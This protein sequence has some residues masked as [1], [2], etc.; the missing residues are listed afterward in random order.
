[1]TKIYNKIKDNKILFIV[2]VLFLTFLS[3]FN[4]L[5]KGIIFNHDINFHLHRI[6]AL[7]DSIRIHKYIPVYF[8]YLNGFGYGNGLFYPDIF[9]YIPACLNYIGLSI[10]HSY[11]IFVVLINLLSILTMYL[12]VIRITKKKY[13]AYTSMILYSCSIYRLI[14][15]VERGSLGEMMSFIF[16][17]LVILGLYEILYG[18]DKK[19]ILLSLGLIGLC[20]SHVIT[21][22]LICIS[23]GIIVLINIK[24]LKDKKRLFNLL[25][26]IVIS[27][28]VTSF[29]WMPMLE[30]VFSNKFNFLA[31][32]ADFYNNVVP[33][34]ALFIDFPLTNMFK[35]WVP[36]GI[37]L[38]YYY[39]IYKHFKLRIKDKFLFSIYTVGTLSIVMAVFKLVWK[40]D[41][42]KRI[43]NIIQFPWRFYIIATSFLTIGLSIVIKKFNKNV[44][45]II[46]I[47][48]VV[49]FMGN[50]LLYTFNA[51]L[52]D[53]THDEIMLGEYL[54]KD[55][56]MNTVNEYNN[57]D[58]SYERID[59]VTKIKINNRKESIEAPLIYYKGY[60]ACSDKC[61]EV[62]KTE[63]GLLG[64]KTN[65]ELDTI[66]VKY[67][68]TSLQKISKYI[69]LVSIGL[70]VIYLKNNKVETLKKVYKKIISNKKIII[71]VLLLTVVS[72][73]PI[74]M[75][76]LAYG[77]D[78]NFH[79]K[80]I[81]AI[82]LNIKNN[83]FGYPIYFNYLN[84]YGYASGLF[85]PDLFLYF[86]AL[87]N[88]IGIQLFIAYR[89]FL[90]TIKLLG[91]ISIY[92]SV[93]AITKN[94]NCAV[95]SMVLYAFASY[96]FIDMF[97]RGALAETLT[98]I[99]IP[100]VIRGIYEI[101]YN[102]EKKYY[103]LAFGMLGILYSHVI[104]TYLITFFLMLFVL[105]NIKRLN[106]K[107]I[108]SI[109]KV[110]LIFILIG[111]YFIF[112]LIE[113]MLSGTF[114]YD[115]KIFTLME[116][117][118]PL[119]C[120]IPELPYYSVMGQEIERWLPCGVG[121]IYLYF[122][123]IQI[124]DKLDLNEFNKKLF[125]CGILCLLFSTK[126][127]WYIPIMNKLFSVIQFP[128]RIYI[129]ETSLFIFCFTEVY[130][131]MNIKRIFT[132]CILLF[133]LNLFYP[134]MN[135]KTS[136]LTDNEIMHGEYLPIEY[137]DINYSK[138][139]IDEVT[140]ACDIKYEI[141]HGLSTRITYKSKCE[142]N[143]VEL[144]IIYYKGYEV[145]V[146]DKEV[147]VSKSD[148]GT[149]SVLLKEKEGTILVR[150]KGTVIYN[151]TKYISLIS[152]IG[153]II[154]VKKRKNNI[155]NNS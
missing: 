116:N 144:P 89:I 125:I 71:F 99:F 131:N 155:S 51:Y 8:N 138:D 117:T 56:N 37:G 45:K 21:L 135:I 11:K 68:G 126:L 27:M 17:P 148:I 41:V 154:Y 1:M 98:I 4:L 140:G 84:N 3:S 74:C 106:R 26:N 133:S 19:N 47:Y 146:N 10:E 7:T 110:A 118:V 33:I 53:L 147:P 50:S 55:F 61:Y 112:P 64:I 127:F 60:K 100:L 35:V 44:I 38:V 82:S 149:I 85:Y 96:P 65:N 122:L 46:I 88:V 52:T 76:N 18:E 107:R 14:D 54:P 72:A 2:F 132:I 136:K 25:F 121:I 102:D 111:S 39:G 15:L 124:K 103:I 97:E 6:I 128:Y 32:S 78:L 43:F 93:K 34:A 58:I 151:A 30:Q 23:I 31:N 67:E 101:L 95:I 83:V 49:I 141:E 79:L 143:V 12:C 145:T 134:F 108:I 9:L 86:P 152:L 91:I 69:S 48:T 70:M 120:L 129:L 62:F 153:V 137:P 24:C 90:F 63:N 150:Y 40:I 115:N 123:I 109:I 113:Q 114:Y 42:L 80:R 104:S 139:H 28:A 75:K 66:N 59:E 73:L 94:K 13:C 87:L 22:Y 29:F 57:K 130:K 16:I 81:Q 105:L 20:L 92:C 36:S 142:N 5:H 119:I 77:G